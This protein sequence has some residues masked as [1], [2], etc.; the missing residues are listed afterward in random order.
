MKDKGG[1]KILVVEDD[2]FVLS[3]LKDFLALIDVN[4][5]P[6][7]TGEEV[8]TLLQNTRFDLAILDYELPD[9]TGPEIAREIKTKCPNCFLLLITGWWPQLE[10]EETEIIDRILP[11]PFQLRD[12]KKIIDETRG[13]KN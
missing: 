8:K 1:I 4:F 9:T 11:K 2:P 5:T 7:T 6:A 3:L 13:R 10:K 12:L